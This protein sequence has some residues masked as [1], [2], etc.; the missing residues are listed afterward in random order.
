MNTLQVF[1]DK[2]RSYHAYQARL[3]FL[4]QQRSL[5]RHLDA[6]RAALQAKETALAEKAAAL[7]KIARLTALLQNQ[8]ADDGRN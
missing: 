8:S 2:E 7:A 1:S 3:N 5:Q 6:E 4:R